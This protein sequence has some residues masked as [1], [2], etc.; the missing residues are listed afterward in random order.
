[1]QLAK[2]EVVVL[3]HVQEEQFQREEL[4]PK[5]VEVVMVVIPVILEVILLEVPTE[6]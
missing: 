3:T 5:V 1:M 4:A 6:M 2:K